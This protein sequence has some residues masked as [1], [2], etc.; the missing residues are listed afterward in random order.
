M[1]RF[2]LLLLLF[3]SLY[4]YAQQTNPVS[5]QQK[6][7]TLQRFLSLN[8]YLPVQWDD[9]TSAIL[10]NK[11]IEKLDDE[12]LFFTQVEIN[13]LE[14][15]KTK[16]DDELL[17]KPLLASG[18]DF[19]TRSTTL[20]KTSLKRTDSILQI[21]L[22]KPFDFSKPDNII[23]PFTGYAQSTSEFVQRWQKFLKWRVLENIADK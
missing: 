22:A 13:A 8:H 9:S 11:W 2:S 16:L 6:F 18:S 10:Y 15:F 1:K 5:F 14:P 7:F 21:L 19:F 4:S 3:T 23:W 12:K 17:I 20:Y